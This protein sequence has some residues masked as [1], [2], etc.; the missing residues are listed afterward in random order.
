M[1]F[2]FSRKNLAVPF[3][4]FLVLFVIIPIL[5]VIFY[6]FTDSQGNFSFDAIVDF[7]TSVEKLNVLLISLLIGLFNTVLCLLIGYPLAYLLANKNINKNYILVMLF[8]MPM[9]INFVLRTGALRDLLNWI[10][11]STGENPLVTTMIGMV[12]NYLPFTILPLYSTMLKLD[13]SQIE[14]A[15]DLGC[16]RFQV[17]TKSIIPQTIPGITSAA[18]MVFMPTLSSYVISDVLSEGKITLFGSSIYIS[19]TNG[20]ENSGS[21]MALIML[22]IIFISMIATSKFERNPAEERTNLW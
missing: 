8:V 10:G 1:K 16:N 13:N 7:F 3:A 14:A 15:M 18:M 5:I 6:A 2:R 17:F 12:S 9:W 4:V 11:L 20:Q 19:Y 21:V 22:I